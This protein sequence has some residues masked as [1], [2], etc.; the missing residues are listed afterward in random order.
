MP[1]PASLTAALSRV[2]AWRE[3]KGWALYRM[4]TLAGVAEA[5]VRGMDDADWNPTLK[6]LRRLEALI[7]EGW[8]PGD[9]VPSDAAADAASASAE[10]EAA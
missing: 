10:G 7:P 9:P 6:T 3:T 2:R 1:D 5:S 4:A 8:R